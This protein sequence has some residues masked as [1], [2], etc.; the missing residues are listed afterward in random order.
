[1][2]LKS[3]E[4]TRRKRHRPAD[5][6]VRHLPHVPSWD[7]P[8]DGF[9]YSDPVQ[10]YQVLTPG[11]TK[12]V[13]S[14]DVRTRALSQANEYAKGKRFDPPAGCNPVDAIGYSAY[15]LW[16]DALLRGDGDPR[17][18]L[19]HA[20]YLG[21]ARRQASS[22]VREL[23]QTEAEAPVIR[24]TAPRDGSPIKFVNDLVAHSRSSGKPDSA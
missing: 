15:G 18:A 4:P 24:H 10:W 17:H 13:D 23:G 22:F 20:S 14:K 21:W 8:F 12:A 6:K 3:S 2:S 9:G 7:V 1:M 5:L 11:E 19:A 16:K